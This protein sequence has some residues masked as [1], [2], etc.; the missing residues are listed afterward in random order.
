MGCGELVGIHINPYC[1]GGTLFGKL[2][3]S[4]KA[5]KTVFFSA[6]FWIASIILVSFARSQNTY[7]AMWFIATFVY[8]ISDNSLNV[9]ATTILVRY[10][11]LAYRDLNLK[12]N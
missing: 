3:D 7:T 1:I 10:Y 4:L 2:T 5:K 8:G 9:L 12:A 6:G 11:D